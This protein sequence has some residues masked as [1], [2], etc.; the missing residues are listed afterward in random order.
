MHWPKFHMIRKLRQTD[1]I[2][3]GDI[4]HFFHEVSPQLFNIHQVILHGKRQIH[5]VVQVYEVVLHLFEL[6]LKA[7]GF[8]Y[9]WEMWK[10]YCKTHHSYKS[11]SVLFGSVHTS[12]TVS[13]WFWYLLIF[14]C[15]WYKK[16]LWFMVSFV[17]GCRWVFLVSSLFSQGFAQNPVNLIWSSLLK[18]FFFFLTDLRLL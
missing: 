13:G 12:H 3:S 9:R 10:F 16:I 17:C 15:S 11:S 4:L 14:L 2:W 18:V 8:S 1:P 7:L 5:Q 6:H